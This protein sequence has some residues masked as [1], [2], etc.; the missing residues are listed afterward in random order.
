[1]KLVL[2]V[3]IVLFSFSLEAGSKL[4]IAEWAGSANAGTRLGQSA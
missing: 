1:M 2:S 3:I 4:P